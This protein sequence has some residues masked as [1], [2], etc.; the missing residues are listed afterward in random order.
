[1]VR[2]ALT[3]DGPVSIRW[4]KGEAHT[5]PDSEVGSGLSGRKVR[6]GKDACI[7]AVGRL[8][9][10][11]LEAA[12]ELAR[13]GIEAAVWDVR[14]VKPLDPSML[15][16][17][18]KHPLVVTVEDGV[19]VGGAGSH[20]DAALA[21]LDETRPPVLTLGTPLE[22]IPQAKPASILARLGL[23]GAGI[24]AS[25]EKALEAARP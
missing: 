25:V 20:I 17:A 19:R 11:A 22:F 6:T 7:L 8:L 9:K 5:S 2:E 10:P 12:E 14:V 21:R 16:D 13:R 24:A 15:N 3:L 1:M 18:V 23:D 4:P